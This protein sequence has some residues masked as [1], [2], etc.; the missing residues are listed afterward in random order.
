[1]SR[2]VRIL[3]VIFLVIVG[4]CVMAYPSLSNYVNLLHS[5]YAV[6]E[7]SEQIR[8]TDSDALMQQ[9]ALAEK[10]NATL[11]GG[12]SDQDDD[13]E[14]DILKQYDQI[15][16]FGNGIMGYIQIPKI[17]VELSIYHGVSGTVLQK[18]VGHVAS[19]AFPIGGVGNHTVLT[20]HTGLPS[21]ELFTDLTEMGE[22]DQFYLY[23]LDEVLVYEVDQITVVLP[24]EVDDLTPAGDRDY[25]TLVTCTPYGINSH[26]LLVRGERVEMDEEIAVQQAALEADTEVGLPLEL[27]LAGAAI[28][29]LL[30]IA[31]VLMIRRDPG[32]TAAKAVDPGSETNK[33]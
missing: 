22:G 5:S 1:M 33:E 14:A 31:I 16:D 27:I 8:Q 11:S 32:E 13:L 7:F 28:G 2:K 17:G 20:G 3:I 23:V 30:I 29:V 6:Q 10:Y 9:R 25:C 15:M 19:S 24:H 4:I 26:R 21:A 12:V 18:G